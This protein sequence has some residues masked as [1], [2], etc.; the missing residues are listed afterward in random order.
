M[1]L[2][3]A[4]PPGCE[5]FSTV[6]GMKICVRL[7]NKSVYMLAVDGM[8]LIPIDLP[9]K[10]LIAPLSESAFSNTASR[11]RLFFEHGKGFGAKRSNA[12]FEFL[13]KLKSCTHFEDV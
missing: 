12:A 9:S 6:R 8:H 1:Q 3:A 4:F 11:C 5:F 13:S 7:P 2:P 10:E